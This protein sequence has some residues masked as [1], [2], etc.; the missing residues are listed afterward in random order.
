[1]NRSGFPEDTKGVARGMKLAAF[2]PKYHG[3]YTGSCVGFTPE[4]GEIIGLTG[5]SEIALKNVKHLG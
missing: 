4:V 3:R 5:F 1:V 2:I